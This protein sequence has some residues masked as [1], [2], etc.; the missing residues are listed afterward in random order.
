[1]VVE[2]VVVDLRRDCQ[3]RGIETAVVVVVGMM[4]ERVA[5][6]IIIELK[7]GR[8]VVVE[9]ERMVGAKRE[10]RNILR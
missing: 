10:V 2:V 7:G 1:M 5:L 8:V 3:P 6:V 4:N 9:I